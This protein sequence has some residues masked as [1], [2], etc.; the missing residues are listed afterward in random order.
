MVVEFRYMRGNV[1]IFKN[2]EAKRIKVGMT[3]NDPLQRL[4]SLNDIWCGW[5]GLCQVCGTRRLVDWKGLMPVH[6]CGVNKCPGSKEL[7]MERDVTL[8]EARL[9]ELEAKHDRLKGSEKGSSTRIIKCLKD[10]I[11]KYRGWKKPDGFWEIA[12]TYETDCAEAVELE[13]HKLL[14]DHLDRNAPMGEVYDCSVDVARQAV[15]QVLQLL[16]EMKT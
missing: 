10:R 11:E 13:V 6:Y 3:I 7:P 5:K 12:E 1:Y 15:E 9:A 14:A 16:P 4:D 8:A 2:R